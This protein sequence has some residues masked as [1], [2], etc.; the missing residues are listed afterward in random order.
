MENMLRDRRIFFPPLSGAT[1]LQLMKAFHPSSIA[2]G[3]RSF[4]LKISIPPDFPQFP[5][6]EVWIKEGFLLQTDQ[7]TEFNSVGALP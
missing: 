3:K 6:A 2:R 7:K 1:E 5:R 4:I